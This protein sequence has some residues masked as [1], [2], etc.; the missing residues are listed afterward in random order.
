M[1]FECTSPSLCPSVIF[2]PAILCRVL[3]QAGI[4]KTACADN[5]LCTGP[6]AVTPSCW[7]APL[8]PRDLCCASFPPAISA[9]IP[10]MARLWCPRIFKYFL[11]VSFF[12]S[13]ASVTLVQD[14]FLHSFCS[15]TQTHP[16]PYLPTAWKL[17]FFF[18]F[19]S[20]ILL[21]VKQ[22]T[23]SCSKWGRDRTEY[24]ENISLAQ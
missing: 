20:Q 12:S 21:L 3:P 8:L 11:T 1:E 4:E 9:H 15:C 7:G 14:L 18:S 23:L 2:F 17:D 24:Q 13:S 19:C 6:Q 22:S 10:F 16:R 5:C